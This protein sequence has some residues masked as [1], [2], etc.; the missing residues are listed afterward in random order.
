MEDGV[1]DDDMVS[2]AIDGSFCG[3]DDVMFFIRVLCL[4]RGLTHAGMIPEALQEYSL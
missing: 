1:A 4:F 3:R 2:V